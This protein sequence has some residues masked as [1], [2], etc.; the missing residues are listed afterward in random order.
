MA[1]YAR[2]SGTTWFLAVM[3]GPD[4]KAVRVP[5]SFLGA[6]QYTTT[7]VR[8]DGADAASVSVESGSHTRSDTIAMDVRAGG[9]L[10]VRFR[11]R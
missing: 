6:G 7:T 2:R 5:L 11:G 1:I 9:G 3:C 8:D 10:L 4:A